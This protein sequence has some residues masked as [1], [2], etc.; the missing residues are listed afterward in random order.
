MSL[1]VSMLIYTVVLAT[2]GTLVVV[3]PSQDGLV[4]AAD[5]RSTVLGQNFDGIGKLQIARTHRPILVTIT[6]TSDFA[7][8]PPPGVSLKEWMPKATYQYRGNPFVQTL[9][10]KRPEISL[11]HTSAAEV[12]SA[13]ASSLNEFLG[14]RPALTVQYVSQDLCRLVL[15]QESTDGVM[16]F[17]SVPLVVDDRGHVEAQATT[18]K[19]YGGQDGKVMEFI[20]ED[21]YTTEHVLGSHGTHLLDQR[22]ADILNAKGFIRDFRSTDAAWLAQAI[23]KAAEATTKIVP[24]PSGN[25][26]GGPVA[27]YLVTAKHVSPI[28]VP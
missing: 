11:S 4:V 5:S 1:Y 10:E 15:C 25:G 24:V 22:A 16:L 18:F 14:A 2:T 7:D 21:R 13:L 8:P 28:S 3:V 17:A 26:I 27:I 9:L 12:A 6:G 20:G 23:I 19:R